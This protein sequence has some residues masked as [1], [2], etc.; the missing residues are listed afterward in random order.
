MNENPDPRAAFPCRRGVEAALSSPLSLWFTEISSTFVATRQGEYPPYLPIWT[1]V[2]SA[3]LCAISSPPSWLCGPP[4][5]VPRPYVLCSNY[6]SIAYY[7]LAATKEIH[8]LGDKVLDVSDWNLCIDSQ[9]V[10]GC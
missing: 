3:N 2:L 1:I 9:I 8:E 6:A 10:L 4:K 7:W 5:R